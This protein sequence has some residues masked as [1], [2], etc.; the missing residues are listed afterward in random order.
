MPTTGDYYDLDH[1]TRQVLETRP[2]VRLDHCVERY[3][4]EN[5]RGEHHDAC[6]DCHLTHHVFQAQQ[7]EHPLF[8]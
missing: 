5:T 1:W 8:F 3:G 2:R 4:V 6:T 7:A